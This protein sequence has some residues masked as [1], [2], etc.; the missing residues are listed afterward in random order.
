LQKTF[1]SNLFLIIL[2]NLLVKPLWVLGIDVSVQNQ[3][4]PAVYG[5]YYALLNLGF[6]LSLVLDFGLNNFTNR[7]ISR[8]SE[9]FESSFLPLSLVKV[10]LSIAFFGVANLIVYLFDYEESERKVFMFISLMLISQ[11]VLLFLRANLSGIQKYRQEV[12]VSVLDKSL[13]IVFVAI[14]L[15]TDW[16]SVGLSIFTFIYAQILA[17]VVASLAVIV[18]LLRYKQRA[19]GVDFSNLKQITKAILPYA[20]LGFLMLFY[21]KLDAVMIERMLPDGDLQAGR[22]AQAYKLLDSSVMFA[23]LFSTLLLPMFSNLLSK[24]ESV[25]EL[26]RVSSRL[27]LVPVVLICVITGFYATEIL[28]LLFTSD[29]TET[30]KIFP[31]LMAVLIPLAGSYIY[32]TLI[33]AEGDLKLLNTISICAIVLNG[34]GNYFAIKH[35]GILGAAVVT[36]ITQTFVLMTQFIISTKRFKLGVNS[37]LL[38]KSLVLVFLAISVTYMS[39]FV[40]LTWFVKCIILFIGFMILAFLFKVLNFKMFSLLTLDSEEE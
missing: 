40:G 7:K 35:S 28:D 36:L 24:N 31:Y 16:V 23:L 12:L 3:F 21:F 37:D 32:G 27:L 22:Y 18:M 26:V 14:L 33:T 8:N 15:W 17:Y 34:V 6:L 19:F 25:K 38:F 39:Q 1:L 30:A 20:I 11:Y 10:F 4:G 5:N 9:E 2:L 29:I 13:M